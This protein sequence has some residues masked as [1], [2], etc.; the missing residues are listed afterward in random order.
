[1]RLFPALAIALAFTTPALSANYNMRGDTLVISGQIEDN[2]GMILG[3]EMANNPRS[4][5]LNSTGGKLSAAIIM[6]N[7]IRNR[8]I[9]VIVKSY[10][11]CA[12][13]CFLIFAAG[14]VKTVEPGAKIGVHRVSNSDGAE[15]SDGTV[16]MAELYAKA[17]VP[18]SIIGKMVTTPIGSVT[19][20][21]QN[22]L[23]EMITISG[24][25][26]YP[27]HR[28]EQVASV[29]PS[30][31]YQGH[32]EQPDSPKYASVPQ[33]NVPAY[34]Q[35]QN[36]MA[37]WHIIA[38]NAVRASASQNGGQPIVSKTCNNAGVCQ[39]M[40]FFRESNGNMVLV[41]AFR[42]AANNQIFKREQCFFNSNMTERN[43]RDFETGVVRHEFVER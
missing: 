38:D 30:Q 15:V 41:R 8:N 13:A 21:S 17:G 11:T 31:G 32:Q 7:V 34:S 35:T 26:P 12:S 14:S 33:Q 10:D 4:I 3:R 36:V 18:S 37:R 23:R 22:D 19:W 39:N 9:P 20:L 42:Y 16:M 24:T 27:V 28:D 29:E 6:A 40:V 5:E 43:C 1:M 2:D 25:N